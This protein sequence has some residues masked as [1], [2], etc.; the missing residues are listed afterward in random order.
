MHNSPVYASPLTETLIKKPPKISF[1]QRL[2]W[3]KSK[4]VFDTKPLESCIATSR[5]NFEVIKIPGHAKD[6]IALYEPT[7]KWLFSADLYV[8]DYI[9]FFLKSETFLDQILS[10]KKVLELDFNVLFCAH[11]PQWTNGREKIQ[12][13]LS[14][15]ESLYD[16]VIPH[17]E[18]GLDTNQIMNKLNLKEDWRLRLM[19]T[20][21]LSK[22]NL[23]AALV[24]DLKQGKRLGDE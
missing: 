13:K 18:K 11:N 17:F 23:I 15:F 14:Y 5:F 9:A 21:Y 16:R 4:P 10:L 7:Q 24:N 12:N 20:G 6:M 1:V 2:Y 3:G 22:R 8:N 19:T